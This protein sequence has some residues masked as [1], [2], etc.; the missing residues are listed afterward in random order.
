[1][2]SCSGSGPEGSPTILSV[3]RREV[4]AVVVAGAY[5]SSFPSLESVMPRGRGQT[6]LVVSLT[7]SS[8]YR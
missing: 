7:S 5:E 2:L 1:M 3:A 6:F 8:R 4:S